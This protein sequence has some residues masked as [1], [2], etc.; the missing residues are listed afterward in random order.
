M[1]FSDPPPKTMAELRQRYRHL[2]WSNPDGAH[3]DIYLYAVL[4]SA[5]FYQILDF[6]VVLGLEPLQAAWQRLLTAEPEMARAAR[7]HV[8]RIFRNLQKSFDLYHH[9]HAAA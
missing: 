2:V 7:P 3:D 8:A 6:A 9:N 5:N 1:T 4:A